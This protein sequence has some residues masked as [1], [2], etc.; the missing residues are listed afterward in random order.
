[1]SL[2]ALADLGVFGKN[3]HDAIC[4]DAKEGGGEE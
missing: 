4:G 2:N 1:M 3:R